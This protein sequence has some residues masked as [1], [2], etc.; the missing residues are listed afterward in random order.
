MKAFWEPSLKYSEEIFSGDIRRAED[1]TPEFFHAVF[2]LIYRNFKRGKTFPGIEQARLALKTPFARSDEFAEFTSPI[3]KKIDKFW[4][5]CRPG[6]THET[7]F[8]FSSKG[9]FSILFYELAK[10]LD[11]EKKQAEVTLPEVFN[12]NR[13]AQIRIVGEFQKVVEMKKGE[14]ANPVV[15]SG[16]NFYRNEAYVNIE[17]EKGLSYG[18][19]L[20]ALGEGNDRAF[21]FSNE[22]F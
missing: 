9:S 19:Y 7:A 17:W 4:S 10:N 8:D 11:F 13:A 20:G 6:I 21:Q 1:M 22:F 16:L 14:T 12:F 2:A 15:I 5:R 3:I 18:M